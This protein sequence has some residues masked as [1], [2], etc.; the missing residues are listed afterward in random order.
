MNAK[1]LKVSAVL[2][3]S[4]WQSVSLRAPPVAAEMNARQTHPMPPR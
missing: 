4:C 2:A 3:A 1:L